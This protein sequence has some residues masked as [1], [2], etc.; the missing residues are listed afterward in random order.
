[1]AAFL[2][3]T[4]LSGQHTLY[5]R[6]KDNNNLWSII[7]SGIFQ[8][9]NDLDCPCAKIVYASGINAA[10]AYQWQVDIGTG[11][12]NISDTGIYF[13]S[14]LDSLKISNPP[15]NFS[16][17]KYRCAITTNAGLVYSN[18]FILRY[19]MRWTGNSNTDWNNIENW[20]CYTIPDAKTDVTVPGNK[21]NYPIL[22]SDNSVNS[23]IM[24]PAS[25]LRIST[26]IK[27]EIKSRQN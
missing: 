17:N 15:T 7:Y 26:G 5:I 16:F 19:N 3:P 2:L 8:K 10:N 11:F 20:G 18:T 21:V 6:A 22:N 25:S 9:V 13:G 27:L 4:P 23:L 1:M 14:H 12:Q 24:N